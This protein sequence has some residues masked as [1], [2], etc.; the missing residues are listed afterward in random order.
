MAWEVN[1]WTLGFFRSR[2]IKLGFL[3]RAGWPLTWRRAG[4]EDW[5][6]VSALGDD[7]DWARKMGTGFVAEFG[8]ET[9]FL[10]DRDWFGWPDPPQW[11]LASFDRAGAKWQLWGNSD[12]L[13]PAWTV[14]DP[15]YSPSEASKE[16]Q[17]ER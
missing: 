17:P 15:L 14:P 6:P 16:V 8:D 2:R 12:T 5:P 3:E 10:I 13:P 9:L 1:P 7:H 11:G 4:L